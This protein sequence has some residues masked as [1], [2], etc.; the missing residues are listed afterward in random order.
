MSTLA[1]KKL[2]C[3]FDVFI[4]GGKG[5]VYLI[6]HLLG[7]LSFFSPCLIFYYSLQPSPL[8]IWALCSSSS[9]ILPPPPPQTYFSQNHIYFPEHTRL[10]ILHACYTFLSDLGFPSVFHT[11]PMECLF[12]PMYH[13]L[14]VL[15]PRWACSLWWDIANV[16]WECMNISEHS[17]LNSL[18]HHEI[19]AL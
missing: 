5:S 8:W 18:K 6:H 15:V 4:I 19:T 16:D 12:I 11:S 14:C 3:N 17:H 10:N 1:F 9:S 7:P 13:I 2:S